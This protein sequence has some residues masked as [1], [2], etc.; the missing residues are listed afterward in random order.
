MQMLFINFRDKQ[1]GNQHTLDQGSLGIPKDL[2][3]S[4]FQEQGSSNK[5]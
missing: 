1:E 3:A 5:L 2:E 4:G